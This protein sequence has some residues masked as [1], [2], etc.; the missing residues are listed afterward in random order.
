MDDRSPV[1]HYENESTATKAANAIKAEVAAV[2]SGVS[3]HPHTATGL[4]ALIGI[5]GF[6]VG[7]AMGYRSAEAAYEPPP[8]RRYW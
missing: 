1:G 2:K 7:H 8:R 6:L 4:L 5:A 3:D